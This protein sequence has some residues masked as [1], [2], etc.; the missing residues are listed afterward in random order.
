MEESF[1]FEP[2][3]NKLLEDKE[4]KEILM[5]WYVEERVVGD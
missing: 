5:K 3:V 2:V 4:F 1:F